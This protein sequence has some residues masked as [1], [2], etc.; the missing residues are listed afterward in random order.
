LR[1]GS[2][3]MSKPSRLI[4]DKNNRRLH[5]CRKDTEERWRSVDDDFLKIFPDKSG[6]KGHTFPLHELWPQEFPYDPADPRGSRQY[7]DAVLARVRPPFEE[8]LRTLVQKTVAH[9]Y[10]TAKKPDPEK[11][12]AIAEKAVKAV[13]NQ[14]T[15]KVRDGG[16]LDREFDQYGQNALKTVLKELTVQVKEWAAAVPVPEKKSKTDPAEPDADAT[17]EALTPLLTEFAKLDGYNVWRRS[18]E[19]IPRDGKLTATDEGDKKREPTLL[20]WIVPVR[21]WAE[22]ESWGEDPKTRQPIAKTTHK[23]GVLDPDYFAWLRDTLKV[24]DDD[25]TVKKEHLDRLDPDCL[26]ALDFNLSAGRHKPFIFDAG[27]HRPPAELIG[28][29]QAIHG[30]VQKRLGK[31]LGMV[32]D[33]S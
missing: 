9:A 17:T 25:A 32:T 4:W 31:L 1:G 33:K 21:Q 11:A 27:Q 6:D 24:F 13:A 23:D 28:E 20:S 7:D 15:R 8:A 30:E 5:R 3:S 18:R 19:T 26:E 16:L 14:L 12:L 22:L 29:L 10:A 2:R